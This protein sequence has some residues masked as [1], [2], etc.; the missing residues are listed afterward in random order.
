MSDTIGLLVNKFGRALAL[1]QNF[2]GWDVSSV[3][4][5]GYMVS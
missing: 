2:G 5:V 1:N 4:D 3:T